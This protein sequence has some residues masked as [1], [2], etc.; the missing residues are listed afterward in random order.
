VPIRNR[1]KPG[2]WL[3]RCQRCGVTNYA[4]RTQK[5]WTGLRVC[6]TCW[7]PRHPQDFVRGVKDDIAP[8]FANSPSDVFL[9]PN[10]VD[11]DDITQVLADDGEGSPVISPDGSTV[12]A[13]S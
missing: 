3:Y 9:L 13:S 8:P 4:S 12:I 6:S 7:E 10:E 1:H 2:D 5:E 11:Y